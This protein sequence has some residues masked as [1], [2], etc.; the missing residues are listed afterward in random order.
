MQFT[1]R[2]WSSLLPDHHKADG[3]PHWID[4]SVHPATKM[5]LHNALLTLHDRLQVLESHGGK[6]GCAVFYTEAG[7]EQM[8]TQ[9]AAERLFVHLP[10][11]DIHGTDIRSFL[12]PEPPKVDEIAAPPEEQLSLFEHHH[13]PYDDVRPE[14]RH[15]LDANA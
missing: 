10:H 4:Y 8:L 9:E 12:L 6:Y 13:T 11:G 14:A 15:E 5:G 7:E 2:Y 3:E 1:V